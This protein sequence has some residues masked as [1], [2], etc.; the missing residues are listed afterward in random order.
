M[1]EKILFDNGW[2]FHKGD[3]EVPFPS[4]K[5][6]VYAQSKTERKLAGPAA[7]AYNSRP[8]DYSGA[9]GEINIYQWEHVE[10]P[11]DYIIKQTP[12]EENNNA[13]GFFE[14]GNAWYRKAF[15]P[16]RA[17]DSRFFSRL[18]QLTAQCI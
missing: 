3:I 4:S 13:L 17:K 12:K 8:D 5:G 9:G 1:R 2:M 7:R 15:K 18:L 16:T 10:L 11:H 14:Y 6:P